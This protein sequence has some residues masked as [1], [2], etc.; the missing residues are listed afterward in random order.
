V[1]G[2]AFFFVSENTLNSIGVDDLGNVRVSQSGSVEV[3]SSLFLG[4]NSVGT[5]DLVEGLESRFSPDDES[6]EVT[7]RSQLLQVKSVDIGDFNTGEVSNSS[8]EVNIFVVVDEEGSSTESVSSVSELS[9]T[10]SDG[11]S[12]GDSFNIFVSTEFL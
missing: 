5:E 7:T 4:G 11:L 1:E 2:S 8:D 10:R 12:V 3:I 6:S 9:F